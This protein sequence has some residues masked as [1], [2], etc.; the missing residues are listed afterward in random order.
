[1]SKEVYIVRPDNAVRYKAMNAI[2]VLDKVNEWEITIQKHKKNK[3]AQQRNYYHKL[4]EILEDFNG[5]TV[6]DWK[7][8][9]CFYNGYY[10][11]KEVAKDVVDPITGEVM[12][13]KGTVYPKRDS[14][15][16][17]TVKKY[18]KLIEDAQLACMTW[19]LKYPQ[20]D[21]YGYDI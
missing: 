8:R 3:T 6:E 13:K 7:E 17:L 20:P 19:E 14:T 16:T 1:M 10:T 2:N 4:L 18:S 15:E 11:M 21:H 9:M 5:D 12:V